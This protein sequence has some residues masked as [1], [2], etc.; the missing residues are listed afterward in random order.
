MINVGILGTGFGETHLQLYNKVEGFEVIA[1]FGR[2]QE[3]LNII[4]GKYNVVNQVKLKE[5]IIQ[6]LLTK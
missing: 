6:S 3:K 1:I 5:M 4:G 2:N